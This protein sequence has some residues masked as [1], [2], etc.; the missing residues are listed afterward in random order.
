MRL[1]EAERSLR[2]VQQDKEIG[3]RLR[4]K[5]ESQVETAQHQVLLAEE[6][7]EAFVREVKVW[8]VSL[9]PPTAGWL[10]H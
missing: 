1:L 9:P 10:I 4:M 7:V 2:E 3:D 5:L 8:Q 6:K